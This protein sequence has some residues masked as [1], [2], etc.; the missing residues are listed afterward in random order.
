MTARTI[1]LPA[2]AMYLGRAHELAES[3]DLLSAMRSLRWRREM[4]AR[5][6]ATARNNEREAQA[7]STAIHCTSD[8]LAETLHK[9]RERGGLLHFGQ[10]RTE[11]NSAEGGFVVRGSARAGAA[12]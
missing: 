12:A 2:V 11:Y 4:K 7:L 1:D 3:F 6:A 10:V 9:L 8:Q 5:T